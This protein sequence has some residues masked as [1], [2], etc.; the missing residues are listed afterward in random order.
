MSRPAWF[1]TIWRG[2]VNSLRTL[3]SW[4]PYPLRTVKVE[5]LPEE[6]T[7]ESIYIA[8]Q[9]QYLWFAAMVCP[10]GCGEKLCM[11]LM[12]D[13]RPKW[14]LAEH[15]DG[16]VSLHPS[17]WRTRGC[18]SHFFIRRGLVEWSRLASDT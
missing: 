8:G 13:G 7:P 16:T 5:E 1:E 4:G 3:F 6:L 12:A 9:G 15:S 18:C 14:Q 2:I 17:V 11:S 10:C